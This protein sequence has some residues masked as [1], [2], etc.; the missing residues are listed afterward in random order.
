VGVLVVCGGV[1]WLLVV[2]GGCSHSLLLLL[3]FHFSFSCVFDVCFVSVAMAN[4][5]WANARAR[6]GTTA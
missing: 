4:A 1:W 2:C 6:K 3:F 5:L